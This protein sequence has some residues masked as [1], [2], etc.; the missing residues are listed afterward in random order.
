MGEADRCPMDAYGLFPSEDLELIF[1]T[2]YMVS[3][4]SGR[5]RGISMLLMC[6]LER[7]FPAW[8]PALLLMVGEASV[9]SWPSSLFL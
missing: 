6:G 4:G 3:L 5:Q 9:C 8:N 1:G 2:F 7:D